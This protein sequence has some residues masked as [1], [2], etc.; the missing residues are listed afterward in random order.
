[1]NKEIIDRRITQIENGIQ[2]LKYNLRGQSSKKEFETNLNN[3][4]ETVEDLKS[5]LERFTT[6]LRN[7]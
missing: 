4:E 3:L 5:Q 1:M 2:K 7:G 6:P